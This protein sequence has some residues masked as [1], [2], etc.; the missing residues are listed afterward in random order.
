MEDY[1]RLFPVKYL[2][3]SW[4]GRTGVVKVDP[5]DQ[6]CELGIRVQRI[7]AP[8][9]T[10]TVAKLQGDGWLTDRR[11]PADGRKRII[12]LGPRALKLTPNDINRSIRWINEFREHG[13]PN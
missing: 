13:L 1:F 2:V 12:S 9:V 3:N 6:V 5:S 4:L 8:T 7:T 10:R 11:D